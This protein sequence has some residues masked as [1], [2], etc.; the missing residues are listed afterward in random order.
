LNQEKIL[1]PPPVVII[2]CRYFYGTT[3]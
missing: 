2:L 3:S 1:A